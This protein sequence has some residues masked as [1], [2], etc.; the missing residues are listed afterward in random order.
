MSPLD[1]LELFATVKA[2]NTE[3]SFHSISMPVNPFTRRRY[4]EAFIYFSN[5][6]QWERV[7]NT[8]FTIDGKNTAWVAPNT[9]TCHYCGSPEHL[10]RQ[11]NTFK[12]R[13]DLQH[14]RKNNIA[15][16]HKPTAKV[17]VPDSQPAPQQQ[18]PSKPSTPNPSRNSNRNAVTNNGKTV[19]INNKQSFSD[20]VAN[21][22]RDVEKPT[23]PSIQLQPRQS[24]GTG[25]PNIQTWQQVQAENQRTINVLRNQLDQQ[26]RL[27]ERQ[28]Q[29]ICDQFRRLNDKLDLLT[30]RKCYSPTED[31]YGS[32]DEQ[33]DDDEM[34]DAPASIPSSINPYDGSLA[35]L[36]QP[37]NP[38]QYLYDML[39]KDDTTTDFA[40]PATVIKRP[41]HTCDDSSP[42]VNTTTSSAKSKIDPEQATAH[43]Q[44]Q[45]EDSKRQMTEMSKRMSTMDDLLNE[46]KNR[47]ESAES[48]AKE[49]L[50]AQKV[51][52]ELLK[53]Q[54]PVL[55]SVNG[56]NTEEL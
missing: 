53:Q 45:L 16:K 30:K 19:T 28:R 56:N 7:K 50:D 37:T 25:N 55:A 9:P 42:S 36:S 18:T 5:K 52:Q 46:Y 13:L 1:V 31:D 32:V 21:R 15:A 51:L 27:W 33:E 39:P 14:A 26:T 44:Y 48:Q 20:V 34:T 17:I 29:E 2:L 38:P 10:Q 43:W 11:C 6:A 4:P 3:A 41:H 24:S 49:A 47:C 8:V 22:H 35:T 54:S 40:T 12:K 23:T